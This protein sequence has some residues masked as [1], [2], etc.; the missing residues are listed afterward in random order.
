M[1]MNELLEFVLWLFSGFALNERTTSW[2]LLCEANAERVVNQGL[3][4][5]LPSVLRYNNEKSAPIVYWD[6]KSY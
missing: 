2:K 6:R 1:S 5:Q 3:T 4:F